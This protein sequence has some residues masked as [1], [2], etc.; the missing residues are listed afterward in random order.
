M[1]AVIGVFAL[2]GLCSLGVAAATVNNVMLQLPRP[3]R[4]GDQLNVAVTVGPIGRKRIE[5][6]TAEGQYL[7]TISLFAVRPG[8]A[9]GTYLIP[10]PSEAVRNGQLDLHFT[11]SSGS[12]RR[13][14]TTEEVTGV[15]LV[16]PG[17]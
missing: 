2:I 12:E 17:Q 5:V 6:T 15:S 13:S 9:G 10:V 16:L 4:P 3:L 11:I 1:R 14:P 8:R 7:G